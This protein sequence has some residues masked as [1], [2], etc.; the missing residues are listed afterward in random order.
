MDHGQKSG[1]PMVAGSNGS[2]TGK[3]AF[4]AVAGHAM[5]VLGVVKLSNGAKLVKMRNPHGEYHYNGPYSKASEWTA[6]SKKE[7]K[8]DSA[9]DGIF[10]APIADWKKIFTVLDI[11]HVKEWKVEAIMG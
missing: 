5:T 8:W 4:N 3:T 2:A 1:F 6:A 10:F 9:D 7:A 11:A